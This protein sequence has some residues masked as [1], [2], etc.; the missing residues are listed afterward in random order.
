M[1]LLDFSS[2]AMSSIF[3]RI[4][5]YDEDKD[6]IRHTM[7][8]IIRKYNVDYR[9]KYG[10]TIVC[11][12]AGNS[13]RRQKFAPYKA[14]RRKNRD[15]SMHDWNGIFNMVNQVREDIIELSPY[16]CIFVDGCEA[17]DAIGWIVHNQHDTDE[18]MLIVSPDNDFKQLQCYENVVQYSN[19][20]KKWIKCKDAEEEL[21]MKIVKGD[22]G[23]GVPNILSDDEVLITE[24]ARQTPV[25][26]KQLKMLQEDPNTWPTRIQKNWLRNKDLIDLQM[27]PPEYKTQIE[28]QFNQE[29]KGN[30]QLWM[31]YLIKY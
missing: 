1:I 10:E 3:P 12:D 27:T 14:N 18:H 25:T 15:N 23:D 31:N 5:D 21:W 22:T 6:L 30:I 2:I 16:R 11:F 13:W 29:P 26:Q 28:E 4:D 24:G 8:N 17:D 9:D 19:I 7:L 20:Q